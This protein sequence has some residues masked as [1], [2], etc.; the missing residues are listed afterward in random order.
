[1]PVKTAQQLAAGGV[2]QPRSLVIAT[3]GEGAAIG[4]EGHTPDCAE[5]FRRRRNA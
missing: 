3:G 2:P 5:M 4:A 1:M